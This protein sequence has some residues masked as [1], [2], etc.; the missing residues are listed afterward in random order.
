MAASASSSKG[1]PRDSVA[2]RETIEITPASCA[3]PM[4]ADLALGQAKRNRGSKARPH[5]P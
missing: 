4:T 2:A 5:M 1:S 3:P